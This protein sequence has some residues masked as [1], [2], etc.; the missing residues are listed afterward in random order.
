MQNSHILHGGPKGDL[1]ALRDAAKSGKKFSNW[2]CLK[3]ARLGDQVFFYILAPESAIMATGTVLSDARRG[4]TWDFEATVGAI[5]LL[6]DPISLNELRRMFP[7]WK[8]AKSP[9]SEVYLNEAQARKLSDRA[10][11]SNP[12]LGKNPI[13][14][15]RGAGFGN[16]ETNARVER[17]AIVAVTREFKRRGFQVRSC[18]AENCGFDLIASRSRK[19][20]HIE[21][22]GVQGL[23]P[24]FIITKN[25]VEA[26]QTDPLFHLAIVRSALTRSPR[27][28]ILEGAEFLRRSERVPISYRAIIKP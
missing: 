20:L 15:S 13:S 12:K 10:K 28:D 14:V 23:Q 7:H 6:E 19:E 5:R 1:T 8:W 24:T 9:Q 27:I 26:A 17:A 21:V 2:S 22:K 18:E 4:K 3:N 11:R 16:A 25:E